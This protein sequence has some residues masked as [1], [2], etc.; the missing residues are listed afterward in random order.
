MPS[1]EDGIMYYEAGQ[2]SNAMTELS[3]SGDHII[4]NSDDDLW[5]DKSGYECNVKPNGLATGGAVSPAATGTD[6]L[7]DVAALTCYLAGVLTEVGAAADETVLRGVT[8]DTHRKSS[9]TI[10]SAGAVA[11]VAGTDHTAFSDVRGA[12]G[13]PP[14]I[15]VGSIEIAQIH[16]TSIAAAPITADEIKSVIGSHV[17]RFDF[18]TWEVKRVRVTNQ[19]IGLAGVD[20]NSALPVIHT[21]DVPKK[22][23]AS[24]YEPSFA[25][26]PRSVDFVPAGE[27]HSVSSKEIYGGTIGATSKSLGQGSFTTYFEDGI[28][29]NLLTLDGEKLWF[30]F[31]Q[32]RL[33]TPYILVQ[34]KLGITQSFPAG[35]SIS[36]ACTITA[37]EKAVRV[38]S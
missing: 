6:D 34:G 27:S 33:K 21:G 37:E 26:V 17:E 22:V 13:G 23:Y 36:G 9:V 1:A 25:E 4:F 5:S 10:T 32:D 11:I 29:D 24:W 28:S 18:P 15:P 20:F 30:K 3:D 35:D 14:Y 16:L 19:V 2:S 38:V 8:T 12:D 7:I 31:K